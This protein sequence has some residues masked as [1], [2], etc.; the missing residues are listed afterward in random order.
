M[1]LQYRLVITIVLLLLTALLTN[2]IIN[3]SISTEQMRSALQN[4][5]EKDLIAKRDL[6]KDEVEFYFSTIE[7]QITSM[8]VDEGVVEATESFKI[9]FDNYASE[10]NLTADSTLAS[11]RSYYDSQF[12]V[13]Y[14]N[15]NNDSANTQSMLQGLDDES[16]LLQ[17][18]FISNNRHPLGNKDQLY[19]PDNNTQYADIHAKYHE[20]FR[21]FLQTFGYYDIFIAD[22]ESGD[23]VYSVFKELDYSTSLRNGPYAN[24]GIGEAFKNA[25]SLPKG[26]TYLT[27]FAAYLPSYNNPASFIGTPVY[28]DGSVI[29]VLIF[30]M[31]IDRINDIMTQGGKWKEKGFGDSGEIYLVGQDKTLRNESRFMVEDKSGYVRILKSR[32]I[33]AA[34][35]IDIKS[36]S[37]SLQPVE[38]PGSNGA[39]NGRSGFKIFDDYRGVSVLSA[40]APVKVGRFTWGILS[41]IDEEEAFAPA[42]ALTTKIWS[43]SILI[44][45]IMIGISVFISVILAKALIKPLLK[46]SQ[47]FQLLTSKDANLTTRIPESSIP[48]INKIAT[49]FNIFI[50]QIRQIISVVKQSAYTISSSSTEL[51]A[52][53]EQTN[54]AAMSQQQDAL[55]VSESIHQ[56]N[57]AIQEVLENSV[58][59]SDN[60]TAARENTVENAH[61]ATQT[62]ENINKLVEEVSSSAETIKKLQSEVTN[63]N[64]VLNVINGIADQ[65][66]L[67]ALNAAIEAARAGEHGRGFAVV[68]DEVRQLASRTQESTVEIQHKI[69]QLTTVADDAVSSMERASDSASSGI[70]LVQTVNTSLQNLNDQIVELDSIN[71]TVA[72]SAEEQKYTIDEISKNVD[73]VGE[74]SKELCSASDEIARSAVSLSEI[75]A[76]LQEQVER[77]RTE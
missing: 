29:A 33:K 77:F 66:N 31:P 1:T 56:F 75:A 11:V 65:T 24:S 34:E 74:S 58:V 26:Q 3:S 16:L 63:I 68:A 76:D 69:V 70:D 19:R 7:G 54:S 9:A 8:A 28:R 72:A 6:I 47:E 50:E 12:L 35:D 67:L 4:Q 23:I 37:I 2:V 45:V 32:G 49:G 62:A 53:T 39:L 21:T 40:Y 10:R 43:T 64:E 46:I 55:N 30:Q 48:E 42:R 25:I 38:S 14:R 73:H 59:A 27:D 18:D 52:T 44:T 60:T 51:S 57:T 5:T 13:E 61:R 41:E 36:T 71:Q 20:T 15:Q 17:Y 22:A